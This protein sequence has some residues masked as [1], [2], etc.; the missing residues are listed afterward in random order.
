MSKQLIDDVKDLMTL[1]DDRLREVLLEDRYNNKSVLREL[2]RRT[3]KVAKEYEGAFKYEQKKSKELP[4][5]YLKNA[6]DFA[7]KESDMFTE[8]LLKTLVD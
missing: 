3:L 7:A 5:R 2:V 1:S 6:I 4:Q 8:D